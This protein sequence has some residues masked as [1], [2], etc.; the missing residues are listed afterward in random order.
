MGSVVLQHVFLQVL[1]LPP[2]MLHT[3]TG[4]DFLPSTLVVLCRYNF[5]TAVLIFMHLSL[6]LSTD[7]IINAR[8]PD[9]VHVI[10]SAMLKT[11]I[12]K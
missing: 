4:A 10:H 9:V 2:S 3:V 8:V 6:I 5:T 1:K 11:L 12:V 7:G